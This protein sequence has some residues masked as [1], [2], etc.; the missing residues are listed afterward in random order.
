MAPNANIPTE[1][2]HIFVIE[3]D[4]SMLET[5]SGVLTFLGYQV[6]LFSNPLEFLKI[7][8]QVAPAIIIT[9]MRMPDMSGVELQA[10][11]LKRGRQVPIIFIS[12][13][14][15]VPQT[16]SAMKQGAIEFLTKPF[17][18][19]Q[20]MQA[21]VRGLKQDAIEMHTH[22]ER[23][24]IE[25]SLKGLAPRERQVFDLLSV[26]FNNAEIMARM[27]IS[28]DTAKQ[29]KSEVMRKLGLRSLSQ[30]I[31]LKRGNATS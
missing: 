25:E 7:T 23:M 19:E 12:G 28:L 21:V 31:A 8:I 10:E 14:S 20:L 15:T 17:E 9:D 1:H 13:E 3:D 22:L 30:L 2:Q 5:L 29:Y 24:A 16:I 27:G 11:L 6:H 4:E 18:R 26:G